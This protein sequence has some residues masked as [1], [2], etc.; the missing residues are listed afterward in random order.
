MLI[1]VKPYLNQFSSSSMEK[2]N[3]KDKRTDRRQINIHEERD[4]R[5]WAKRLGCSV[6]ELKYAVKRAGTSPIKVIRELER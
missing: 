3:E 4:L 1:N 6:E 2:R 5:Y